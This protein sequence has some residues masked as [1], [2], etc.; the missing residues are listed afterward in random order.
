MSTD[1]NQTAL[2]LIKDA[3]IECGGLEDDENPDANQMQHAM[4]TLNRMVKAWSIK[5]LKAWTWKEETL[6][7][8]PGKTSYT[9]GLTGDLV[10]ERPLLIENVRRVHQ[11]N[12]DYTDEVPVRIYSK[13]EYMDQNAKDQAGEVVAVYYDQQ[14]TNGVLYVWQA[15]SET[16]RSLKFSSKTYIQDIDTQDETPY[17]PQEWLEA[18]M[19]GLALRLSSKYGTS[20]DNM[21]M[22]A[23][24]ASGALT[25]AE[26]G[27]QEQGSIYLGFTSGDCW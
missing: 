12:P 3:L 17:F 4:R 23:E 18:I 21:M 14:L 22:I 6:T 16:D 24:L 2:S 5:G 15:P 9:I 10:T 19:Y 8:V 7:L 13:Q 20:P 27:D 11:Y 1:Y 25:N 26:N